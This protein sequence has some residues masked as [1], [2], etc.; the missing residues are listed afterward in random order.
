V[1]GIYRHWFIDL[2]AVDNPSELG[3]ERTF[4]WD[5][6]ENA[7]RLAPTVYL[8]SK[9]EIPY[10]RKLGASELTIRASFDPDPEWLDDATWYEQSSEVKDGL[11]LESDE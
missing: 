11:C 2:T 4:Q 10:I 7:E 3:N 1:A 5:S 6:R 8:F 9:N